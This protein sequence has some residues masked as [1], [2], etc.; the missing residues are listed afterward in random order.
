MFLICKQ[1]FKNLFIN[2]LTITDMNTITG[3]EKGFR[4]EGMKTAA[5]NSVNKTANDFES[6]AFPIVRVFTIFY[7]SAWT[8][9]TLSVAL[10]KLIAN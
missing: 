4:T 5:I 9:I 6:L 2:I 10:L 3:I 7:I 1:K 8:F